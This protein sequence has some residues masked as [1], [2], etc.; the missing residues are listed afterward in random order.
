MTFVKTFKGYE[1]KVQE[2]D[3]TVNDWII[4]NKISL[5]GIQA[6]LGHEANADHFSGDLIYTLLYEAD[7]PIAD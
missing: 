7:Q 1:D 6:S 2:L 5:R 4:R 3:N